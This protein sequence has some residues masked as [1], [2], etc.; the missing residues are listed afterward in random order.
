MDSSSAPAA[1]SP[2]TALFELIGATMKSDPSLSKTL[3]AVFVYNLKD[4]SGAVSSWTIDGKGNSVHKGQPAS[5][6]KADVTVDVSEEDFL[7]LAQKK[8][9]AQS[10]FMKGKLKIKGNLMTAMKFD[11]LVKKLPVPSL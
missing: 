1:A 10:L 3:G 2:S 5:G 8:A 6:A 9:N 4:K 11:Q 7:L